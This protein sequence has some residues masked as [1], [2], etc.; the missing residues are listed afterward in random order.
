MALRMRL[1][2]VPELLEPLNNIGRSPPPQSAGWKFT[3]T[4]TIILMC[5]CKN[6]LRSG[7]LKMEQCL[8]LMREEYVF[9]QDLWWSTRN[10]EAPGKVLSVSWNAHFPRTIFWRVIQKMMIPFISVLL[11]NLHSLPYARSTTAETIGTCEFSITDDNVTT[12]VK[13]LES[14]SNVTLD[15][16]LQI[17]CAIVQCPLFSFNISTGYCQVVKC[18][19]TLCLVMANSTSSIN[20]SGRLHVVKHAGQSEG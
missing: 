14:F 20:W 4:T 15:G 7:C 19:G 2:L 3:T 17:C 13:N 10:G 8:R 1:P 16:C 11:L 18:P 9:F 5:P 12:D 6:S